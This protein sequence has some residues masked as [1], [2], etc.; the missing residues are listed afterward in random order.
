MKFIFK[1]M[2]STLFYTMMF[3]MYKAWEPLDVE[4]T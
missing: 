4:S 2:S 3:T 1:L